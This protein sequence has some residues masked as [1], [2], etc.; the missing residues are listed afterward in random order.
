MPRNGIME[1]IRS[2]LDEAK[3]G[4]EVIALGYNPS[5][6]YKVQGQLRR[7]IATN[8]HEVPLKEQVVE[9]RERF[10][11]ERQARNEAEALAAQHRVEVAR[12]KEENR[13]LRQKVASLPNY[14]AHEVWKLVQPPVSNERVPVRE[15]LSTERARRG[16]GHY[17]VLVACLLWS[18]QFGLVVYVA[19]RPSREHRPHV[20]RIAFVE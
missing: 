16:A 7:H 13:L 19:T 6:V 4:A 12:L 15:D 5:T 9:W 11:A 18:V 3:S 14:L 17:P 1:E 2:L 20:E 8:K 10:L